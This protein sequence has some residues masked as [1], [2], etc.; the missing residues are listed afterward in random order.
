MCITYIISATKILREGNYLLIF[1]KL[2][3]LVFK[4]WFTKRKFR[5]KQD[6]R[7]DEKPKIQI[8]VPKIQIPVNKYTCP[9]SL[10]EKLFLVDF[11][12][13]IKLA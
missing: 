4:L 1:S 13:E 2:Y 6:K 11:I 10:R 5:I 12:R 8:P 7:P 9:S 3:F